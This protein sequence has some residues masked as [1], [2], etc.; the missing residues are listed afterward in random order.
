MKGFQVE[1]FRPRGW[2]L[3]TLKVKSTLRNHLWKG[4][5]YTTLRAM[6]EPVLCCHW[7]AQQIAVVFV[8]SN[9]SSNWWSDADK[10]PRCVLYLVTS[11]IP[12]FVP[13]GSSHDVWPRCGIL[14][15]GFLIRPIK[16]VIFFVREG[17]KMFYCRLP[18]R[19]S[20]AARI[21]N[22]L[23]FFFSV[24]VRPY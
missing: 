17:A 6:L 21:S 9:A 18:C 7:A 8:H 10:P 14:P 22:S 4:L 5:R 11:F 12:W 15:F 24:P 2:N 23:T 3:C 19:R 13:M 1:T 16:K 20:I